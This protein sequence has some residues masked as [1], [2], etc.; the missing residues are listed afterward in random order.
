M[1]AELGGRVIIKLTRLEI[2]LQSSSIQTDF[3][4]EKREIE[5]E[6]LPDWISLTDCLI[7]TE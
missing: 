6:R 2:S 4:T 7:L 5:R 1:V 3:E